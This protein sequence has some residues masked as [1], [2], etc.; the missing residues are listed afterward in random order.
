MRAEKKEEI[1]VSNQERDKFAVMIS[2][3][4]LN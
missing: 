3:E 2:K 1:I 4:I